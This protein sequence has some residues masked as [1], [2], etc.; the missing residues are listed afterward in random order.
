MIVLI[1]HATP[2]VNYN[3]CNYNEACIQLL[4][5]NK[6][7]NIKENELCKFMNTSVFKK[8][9]F[10]NDL[11]IFSSTTPRASETALKLFKEQDKIFK[12]DLF[13]EFDLNILKIP[14]IKM[15]LR[16]WFLF[17]R[18]LWFLGM[19]NNAKEISKEL[20]RVNIAE[21][22]IL[23]KYS[24]TSIRVLV[25]HG[26]F[27]KFLEKNL[28]KLNFSKKTYEKNGCFTVTIYE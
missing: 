13:T 5:Y 22:I 10:S 15:P 26:L 3:I 8:I 9:R 11:K 14:L 20:K 1:R 18:L 19:S 21:Q 25:S 27:C 4:N 12:S 17:S 28:L 7:K 6:T 24:K 23:N 2:I 16:S